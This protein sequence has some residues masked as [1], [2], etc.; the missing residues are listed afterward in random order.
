[1]S[2]VESEVGDMSR[3]GMSTEASRGITKEQS[4]SSA[5]LVS[6]NN[7]TPINS[8]KMS[9][10]LCDISDSDIIIDIESNQTLMYYVSSTSSLSVNRKQNVAI[11]KKHGTQHAVIYKVLINY[12]T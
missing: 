7:S 2:N 3:D 8:F 1:M 12:R 4:N 10:T 9:K 6:V 5:H 11:V